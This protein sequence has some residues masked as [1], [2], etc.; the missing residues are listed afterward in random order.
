MITLLLVRHG[1]TE[2]NRSGR[3]QGQSDTNLSESGV[4][5]AE[6]LR[7]RLSAERID[8]VFS[9]DLKRA[10]DTATII[11]SPHHV[12]VS[13]CPELRELDFGELEGKRYEEIQQGYPHLMQWW[14]SGDLETQAPQ[15]ESPTQLAA[16]VAGFLA[17]L[18]SD[19]TA[20]RV[21]IVA[22]NGT[23]QMLVCLL[24]GI[25]PTYWVRFRFGHASLTM[26][27]IHSEQAAIT[28]LNDTCHL[29]EP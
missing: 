2:W 27:S 11:A 17:R 20:E 7:Q 12:P 18:K 13:P 24:L 21:L 3:F 9:S 26:A 22:H 16:R 19:C 29:R 8:A 28:L 23:L 5:Q 15:G 10:L 1:E 25:S 14:I 6:R 4:Q